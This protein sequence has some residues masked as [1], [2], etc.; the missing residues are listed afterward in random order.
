[1]QDI[2]RWRLIAFHNFYR[3]CLGVKQICTVEE[4]LS[5]SGRMISL[6]DF[7]KEEIISTTFSG[8]NKLDVM[9]FYGLNV[10]AY[11][12]D[13]LPFISFMELFTLNRQ[14]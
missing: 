4:E 8:C 1:M 3:T 2:F 6:H 11:S 13:N 7:T 10:F 5:T 14:R 12:I 9:F